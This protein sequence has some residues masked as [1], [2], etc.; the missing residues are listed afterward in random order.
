MSSQVEGSRAGRDVFLSHSTKD[1]EVAEELCARLEREG[2]SVWIAPRD[3]RPGRKYGEEI[4]NAIEGTKATILVLSDS[5]NES[6]HVHHEIERAVSKGKSV[7]P[8]RVANVPPA[9]ALELFVASSQWID[10]WGAGRAAGFDRLVHALRDHLE[11]PSEERPFQAGPRAT[12]QAPAAPRRAAPGRSGR[13]AVIGGIAAAV[14]L[15]AGVLWQTGLFSSAPAI[16]VQVDGPAEAQVHV[17]GKLVG[18]ARAGKV[19]QFT[20]SPGVHTL[21][22]E[23]AG[24]WPFDKSVETATGGEPVAVRLTKKSSLA[25]TVEPPGATVAIDGR[26]TDG[27]FPV[28]L[29][30]GQHTVVVT[31][32]GYEPFRKAV[33]LGGGGQEQLDVALNKVKPRE[34]ARQPREPVRQ[35]QVATPAQPAS[36]PAPA[37]SDSSGADAFL[38]GLGESVGRGGGRPS[39]PPFG[40][41]RR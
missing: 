18:V 25:L 2:I 37:P 22:V 21:R 19:R 4:L 3:V 27:P 32:P 36:P 29:P 26:R 23:A 40:F 35:P 15:G 38:R 41:P 28:E 10:L 34:I 9:R 6:V 31:A 1:V 20:A 30:D 5:S 33:T 16:A 17:D 11:L 12:T 7:F 24:Y 39:I 8:V 13:W 14:L